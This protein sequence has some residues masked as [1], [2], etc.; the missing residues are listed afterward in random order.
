[1]FD[2]EEGSASQAFARNGASDNAFT[3]CDMTAYYV[4]CTE[5]FYENLRILLSFVSVPYFTQESVD[6]EQGI[7]AQEIRMVADSPDN[8]VFYGLMR[9]LYHRHPIREE[10][11]GTV[12][13]IAQITAQTLY[14]CHKVF[15]NPGNMV[16]CVAGRV[17]P[18]QVETIARQVLPQGT[19]LAVETDPGEAEA[20]EAFRPLVEKTMAVSAPLFQVGFKGEPARAGENARQRLLGGLAGDVLFGPSSPL[21]ARLYAGGLINGSFTGGYEAEEGCAFLAAGGES[22]CPEQVGAAVLEEARRIAQKGIDPALW[23]RQKKARYGSMVRG[24]N[25]LESLCV[26][27]AECH[28]EGEDFLRFPELFHSIHREDARKLIAAWCRK[29]RMSLSVIRPKKE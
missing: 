20:P 9:G 28:F 11:A 16:L 25:S 27:L 8:E 10:L 2:T 22:R 29:E 13:S 14:E 23:E 5:K 18:A 3:S 12:E 21:Y 4:E 24:L 17:D 1:M 7:I 6:Q 19:A 15:Y 26:E